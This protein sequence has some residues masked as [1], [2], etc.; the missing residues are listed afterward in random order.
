MIRSFSISWSLDVKSRRKPTST[1]LMIPIETSAHAHNRNP[2]VTI[3][4][5]ET[6]D[7]DIWNNR[8]SEIFGCIRRDTS[9]SDKSISAAWLVG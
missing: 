9:I 6:L 2:V 7:P 8:T 3:F 5:H 1:P 4:G